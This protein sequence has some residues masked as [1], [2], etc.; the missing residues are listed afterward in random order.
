MGRYD[1]FDQGYREAE[2]E[3]GFRDVPEGTYQVFVDTA[4]IKEPRDPNKPPRLSLWCKI[5]S[6]EYNGA[7]VFPGAPFSHM[8]MVK[9]IIAKCGVDVPPNMAAFEDMIDR[10]DLLDRV[11]DV[12]VSKNGQYT[13][14]R[15]KKFVRMLRQPGSDD[16]PPPHTDDDMPELADF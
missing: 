1:E 13:N 2:A 5:L 6:G 14:A 12:E 9:S 10:G 8:N 16:G 4:E 15:V 3:D 7:M 11:L